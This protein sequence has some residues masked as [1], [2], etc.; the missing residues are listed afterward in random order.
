MLE[1]GWEEAEPGAAP[2]WEGPF[3]QGRAN[4]TTLLFPQLSATLTIPFWQWFLTRF[5][6]KTAVYWG[7]AV[8][9]PSGVGMVFSTWDQQSS[10]RPPW[11]RGCC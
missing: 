11:G 3:P 7:I 4:T 6:K 1:L 10:Q 5:G 8:S 9:V 2:C